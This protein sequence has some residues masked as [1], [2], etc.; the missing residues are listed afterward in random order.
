MEGVCCG[1]SLYKGNQKYEEFSKTKYFIDKTEILNVLLEKDAPLAKHLNRPVV[2]VE[3]KWN[4]DAQTAVTQI[5]E[6]AYPES[7]KDYFGEVLLVGIT[8]DKKTK[9]HQCMIESYQKEE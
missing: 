5:K 3:L 7:L 8:Y 9:E 1:K 4:K 6:R 2:V